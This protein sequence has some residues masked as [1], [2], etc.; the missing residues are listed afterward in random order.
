[1]GD[2]I[3]AAHDRAGIRKL[4]GALRAAG[5][6]EVAIERGDGVLVDALLAAGL[7]AVVI[8]LGR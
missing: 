4:V 2:R 7:T 1:M 6:A 3:S 5:A 8:S